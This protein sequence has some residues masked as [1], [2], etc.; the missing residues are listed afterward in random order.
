MLDVD[1]NFRA[2]NCKHYQINQSI[3][4]RL[5]VP[6]PTSPIPSI[7]S[8]V[9]ASHTTTH[10]RRAI[11]QPIPVTTYLH[12]RMSPPSCASFR[13]PF[14]SGGNANAHTSPRTRRH[15]LNIMQIEIR[16]MGVGTGRLVHDLQGEYYCSTF[17]LDLIPFCLVFRTTP[18]VASLPICTI[19]QHQAHHM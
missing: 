10:N 12:S 3:T 11:N 16:R 2:T 6:Y 5:Q 18:P 1:A 19:V 17:Q 14:S 13:S 9:K 15:E 7:H 4:V 8:L